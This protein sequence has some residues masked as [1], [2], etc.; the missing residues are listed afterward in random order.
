M[1]QCTSLFS[2]CDFRGWVVVWEIALAL[3]VCRRETGQSVAVN[4]FNQ[5]EIDVAVCWVTWF[6]FRVTLGCSALREL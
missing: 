5:A 4:G 1:G 2:L 6:R 3:N